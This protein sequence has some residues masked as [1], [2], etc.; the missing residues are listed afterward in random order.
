[1]VLMSCVLSRA[2]STAA[3]IGVVC[4]AASACES[5]LVPFN[6][7]GGSVVT[8][9]DDGAAL[10]SAR[11]FALPDTIV[12]V[13]LRSD[14]IG[15]DADHQITA[16]IRAHLISL[17]WRDVTGDPVLRPDVVVLV[18]ASTRTQ[19]GVAYGNW[20]GTWGYLPYWDAGVS[21]GW[22]WGVPVDEIPYV[23]QAGTLF[24]TMLDVRAQNSETQRI[25][26][27]WAAAI[28]GFVTDAVT[29]KERTLIGIDQ[30]F[31]QSSYLKVE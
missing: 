10:R 17:G 9:V 7:V 14:V 19:A 15:H 20:Y 3:A 12:D 6:E 16:D 28:D 24:I 4:L 23:Y 31:T 29:T 25:P 8:V 1:M 22:G 27:L 21:A 30:A 13:P 18:A 11:T 5:S 26:M 2:C